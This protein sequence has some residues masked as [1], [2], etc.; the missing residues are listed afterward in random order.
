[1]TVIVVRAYDIRL[2]CPVHRKKT[3]K[4]KTENSNLASTKKGIPRRSREREREADRKCE[5]VKGMMERD[6][7]RVSAERERERDKREAE[8]EKRDQVSGPLWSILPRDS[9]SHN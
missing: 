9:C 2:S 1:M 4:A 7:Q 5:T 6:R 8:K 3:R